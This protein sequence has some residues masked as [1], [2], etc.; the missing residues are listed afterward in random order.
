MGAPLTLVLASGLFALALV[1]LFRH[2]RARGTRYGVRMRT[3]LDRV[4]THI[5][6]RFVQSSIRVSGRTMRQ[7][8]HFIFHQILAALLRIVSSVEDRIRTVMHLNK[9]R[10]NRP[11]NAASSH[12]AMINE[13]KRASKLSEDEQRMKKDAAL[14]GR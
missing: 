11:E 9:K 5:H 7:S 4:V 13:H 10:A 12:L 1:G 6:T 2:E 8:V 3:V 14:H